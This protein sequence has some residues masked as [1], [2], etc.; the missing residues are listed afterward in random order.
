MRLPFKLGRKSM[1]KSTI[2][3]LVVS[4]FYSTAGETR[5][6]TISN[7]QS[8]NEV[9]FFVG[10]SD[11]KSTRC[12]NRISPGK[13]ME[14]NSNEK[15]KFLYV[16]KMDGTATES[17][18]II[19]ISRQANPDLVDISRSKIGFECNVRGNQKSAIRKNVNFK[20][21]EKWHSTGQPRRSELSKWLINKFHFKYSLEGQCVATGKAGVR[22]RFKFENRDEM[23]KR[24][25]NFLA[26]ATPRPKIIS[27]AEAASKIDPAREIHVEGYSTS[28]ERDSKR[29]CISHNFTTPK[30]G[31]KLVISLDDLVKHKPRIK[32]LFST[33]LKHF[34]FTGI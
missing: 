30:R 24:F 19:Q 20:L 21:Y 13:K 18:A 11:C 7:F 34:T 12:L 6:C 9:A 33:T 28:S 3:F 25:E 29:T 23:V 4:L 1:K 17:A 32:S 2:S 31:E 14:L 5:E 16:P 26:F 27:S 10:P 22:E 15:F 8:E